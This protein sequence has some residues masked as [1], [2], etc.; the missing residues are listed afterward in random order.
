MSEVA[1]F[2]VRPEDN[3]VDFL[4]VSSFSFSFFVGAGLTRHA[5]EPGTSTHT[6][7]PGTS[8]ST[9]SSAERSSSSVRKTLLC[10]YL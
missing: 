9:L 10:L 1:F 7:S 2:D 3:V 5:V 4:C 6:S 8:S